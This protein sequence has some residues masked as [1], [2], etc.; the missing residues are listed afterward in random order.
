MKA[1]EF[2]QPSLSQGGYYVQTSYAAQPIF[3]IRALISKADAGGRWSFSPGQTQIHENSKILDIHKDLFDKSLLAN[4]T[5]LV[6]PD[7]PQKVRWFDLV[8]RGKSLRQLSLDW[9]NSF[10]RI[11]LALG[12]PSGNDLL[13]ESVD[14]ELQPELAYTVGLDLSRQIESWLKNGGFRSYLAARYLINRAATNQ[15]EELLS[16]LN[17]QLIGLSPLERLSLRALMLARHSQ[18]S[19]APAKADELL[20]LAEDQFCRRFDLGPIEVL[21]L[22]HIINSCSLVFYRNGH[23]AKTARCAFIV[24]ESLVPQLKELAVKEHLLTI[25]EFH[26][27]QIALKEGDVDKAV[28]HLRVAHSLGDQF[29][30]IA[31]RLANLLI[32]RGELDTARSLF[33]EAIRTSPWPLPYLNDYGFLLNELGDSKALSSWQFILESLALD[34]ALAEQS[35]GG[36]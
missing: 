32:D 3:V 13:R 2:R 23:F 9:K 19:G 31:Y 21:Q 26:L 10:D 6:A 14:V 12:L 18:I 30:D 24:K 11:L 8:I 35:D 22:A 25:A 16:D 1:L 4:L 28:D 34:K 17:Y 36:N 20:A 33:E 7:L 27:S 15:V 5:L 29:C